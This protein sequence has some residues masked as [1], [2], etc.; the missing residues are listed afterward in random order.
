MMSDEV[1]LVNDHIVESTEM[2]IRSITSNKIQKGIAGYCKFCGEWSK[3]LVKGAC[4]P[5]RDRYKLP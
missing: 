3:R 4:A 5:C 1:D 2:Q